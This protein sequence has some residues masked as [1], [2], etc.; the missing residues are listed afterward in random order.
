M[1]VVAVVVNGKVGALTRTF[2]DDEGASMLS[3]VDPALF[4]DGSN[5]IELV[6]VT[7]SGELARIAAP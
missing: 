1:V 5:R 4:V 2:R 6:E 3:L 7:G